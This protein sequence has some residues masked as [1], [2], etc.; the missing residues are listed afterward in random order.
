[1]AIQGGA[2]VYWASKV[3]SVAFAHPKIGE[4][5]ADLSSG[6]AEVY[7]AANA[8]NEF[9][10]LSYTVDEAGMEFPE[11]IVLQVDNTTAETFIN[12]TA[13]KSKLKHIDARQEWV[14]VLRDKDILVPTHVPS[15]DN[16]ADIFTKILERPT[17]ELLRDLIMVSLTLKTE[18]Y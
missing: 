14:R 1:M 3:S 4:A 11:P 5:H 16:I 6:A 17:F 9:L 13:F 18:N 7:A 8:C 15:K 12:H 10:Y 2:P